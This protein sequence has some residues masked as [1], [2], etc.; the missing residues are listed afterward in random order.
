VHGF[1]VGDE[2]IDVQVGSVFELHDTHEYI[3]SLEL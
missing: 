3:S 2:L 1:V